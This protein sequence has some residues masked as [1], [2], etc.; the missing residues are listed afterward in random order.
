MLLFRSEEMVQQWCAQTNMPLG[1][2][3]S[4]DHIWQLSQYWYADRMLLQYPKR[5]AVMV[6]EIF[7]KVGLTGEFWQL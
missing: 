7:E 6:A 5:T 1:Q 3:L 4:L 2:I